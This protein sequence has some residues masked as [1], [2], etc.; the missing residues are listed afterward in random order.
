MGIEVGI[1]S[2]ARWFKEKHKASKNCH[3]YPKE[4]WN[5]SKV[6][7][8]EAQWENSGAGVSWE[9]FI[10]VLSRMLG[11]VNQKSTTGENPQNHIDRSE[12][13]TEPIVRW[14]D[15]QW[16]QPWKKGKEVDRLPLEATWIQQMKACGKQDST[17]VYGLFLRDPQSLRVTRLAYVNKPRVVFLR[18]SLE[19][20]FPKHVT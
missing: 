8:Q 4:D 7:T 16:E 15:W 9:S 5:V 1:Q 18:V 17:E 11:L 20:T 14:F 19:Q 2:E 6:K 12:T 3:P 10:I 13:K